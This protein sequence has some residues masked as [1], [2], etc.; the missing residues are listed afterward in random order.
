MLPDGNI[1]IKKE[2][3]EECE[4]AWAEA[5]YRGIKFPSSKERKKRKKEENDASL[6]GLPST[7]FFI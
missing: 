3:R 1:A 2:W 6:R 4:G 7:S 5:K